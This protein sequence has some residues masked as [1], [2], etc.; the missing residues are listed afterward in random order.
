MESLKQTISFFQPSVVTLQETK[1]RKLGSIHLAGYQWTV[2]HSETND[3]ENLD[4]FLSTKYWKLQS[5]FHPTDWV[6]NDHFCYC[7]VVQPI[8]KQCDLDNFNI[9]VN[10]EE[11]RKR[12]KKA[13]KNEGKKKAKEYSMK[14]LLIKEDEHSKMDYLDYGEL[15]MQEYFRCKDSLDWIQ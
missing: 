2:T 6:R 5:S 14:L 3:F 12:S 4:R 15:Q 13:F 9:L 11:I 8:Q 7:S 1:T 10:L